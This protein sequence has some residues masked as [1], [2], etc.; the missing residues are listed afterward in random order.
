MSWVKY[1]D[2]AKKVLAA[3]EE[4]GPRDGDGDL[5]HPYFSWARRLRDEIKR[6]EEWQ[7]ITGKLTDKAEEGA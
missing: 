2:S 1:L 7:K 3:I 6:A 5:M 4:H